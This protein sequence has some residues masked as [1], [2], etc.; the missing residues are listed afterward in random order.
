MMMYKSDISNMT[1]RDIWTLLFF[2]GV[3]A[4][5]VIL[6][7]LV[8]K[9]RGLSATKETLITHQTPYSF[10]KFKKQIRRKKVVPENIRMGKLPGWDKQEEPPVWDRPEEPS[11][12]EDED[13][14]E[15]ETVEVEEAMA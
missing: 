3:V 5:I 2:N 15:E 10:N 9:R 4:I 13:F 6:L 7:I 12:E 11:F 8:E 14:P 1:N